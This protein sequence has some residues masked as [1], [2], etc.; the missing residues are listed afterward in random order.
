[1]AIGKTDLYHHH[2]GTYLRRDWFRDAGDVVRRPHWH[3]TGINNIGDA[4]NDLM[5]LTT[6]IG[7]DPTGRYLPI[8]SVELFIREA[9]QALQIDTYRRGNGGNASGSQ[10]YRSSTGT[11]SMKWA[12][13]TPITGTPTTP[14][15]IESL[16]VPYDDQVGATRYI[17]YQTLAVPFEAPAVPSAALINNAV[18]KVNATPVNIVGDIYP[19][20]TLIFDGGEIESWFN[21]GQPVFRGHWL[22][23][24][25]WD[26]WYTQRKLKSSGTNQYIFVL[27]RESIDFPTLPL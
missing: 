26:K 16:L 12:A 7:P 8:S 5:P 19:T 6:N 11:M 21:A 14:T 10:L 4:L 2:G 17:G 22:Y 27:D 9:G 24:V 1:M 15:P 18:G 20:H 3:T 13:G 23:R 25:R